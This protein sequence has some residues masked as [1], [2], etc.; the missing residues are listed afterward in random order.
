[1]RVCP[2]ARHQPLV[3]AKQRSRTDRKPT[4]PD[5]AA[6]DSAQPRTAGPPLAV[7]A[8][9]RAGAGSRAR[10][11]ARGSPAPSTPTTGSRRRSARTDGERPSTQATTTRATSTRWGSRRYPVTASA[12]SLTEFS[13]PTR[14]GASPQAAVRLRS[15]TS[16]RFR[17]RWRHCGRS[18]RASP[19]ASRVT[20]PPRHTESGS[21]TCCGF[22]GCERRARAR[23]TGV[24]HGL[25]DGACMLLDRVA[26]R[27]RPLGEA[28]AEVVDRDAAEP[29]AQPRDDVP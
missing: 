22:A 5:A 7:A 24:V 25:A 3:P 15:R 4:R 29:V 17:T 16:S 11:A 20:A 26:V 8:A 9:A 18:P 14:S 27:L 13:N 12:T 21:C 23:A 19:C 28:E 6:P 1:M 10:A 2:A